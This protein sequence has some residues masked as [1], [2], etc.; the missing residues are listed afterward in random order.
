MKLQKATRYAVIAVMEMAAHPTRPLSAA[1][2]AG[3]FGLSANHMAKVLPT[4]ARA[5]L[6]EAVRG[7]QGG[8]RL[9]AEPSRLTLWD[10]VRVIEPPDPADQPPISAQP[11]MLAMAEV[12]DGIEAAARRALTALTIGDMVGRA[13][14]RGR[15]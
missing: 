11:A 12:L 3:K 2:I 8:Y 7:A 4:L 6:A 9:V 13:K 15:V 1:E 14:L 10:V 5:G